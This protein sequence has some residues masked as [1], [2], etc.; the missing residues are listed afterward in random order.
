MV[1]WGVR[2]ADVARFSRDYVSMVGRRALLRAPKYG[3]VPSKQS[4]YVT[5]YNEIL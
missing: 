2:V 4:Q 5:R 1:G 3:E